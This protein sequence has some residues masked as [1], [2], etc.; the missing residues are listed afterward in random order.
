MVVTTPWGHPPPTHPLCTGSHPPSSGSSLAQ[1]SAVIRLA[2]KRWLVGGVGTRGPGVTVAPGPRGAGQVDGGT[3]HVVA[4]CSGGSSA[5]SWMLSSWTW[6]V[7]RGWRSFCTAVQTRWHQHRPPRCPPCRLSLC[8]PHLTVLVHASLQAL[9]EPAGLALVAVSLVHWAQPC[10]CLAPMGRGG[11]WL[12]PLRWSLSPRRVLPI[13]TMS[14][15]WV[16]STHQVPHHRGYPVP[17]RCRV[18]AGCPVPVNALP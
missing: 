11:T 7:L 4:T 15:P 5:S 18:P 8:V 2:M 13:G 6:A 16:P 12:Q 3:S 1:V 14:P 10:P 17:R 9:L